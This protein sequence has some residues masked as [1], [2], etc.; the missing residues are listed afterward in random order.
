MNYKKILFIVGLIFIS[1]QAM[2]FKFEGFELGSSQNDVKEL[3]DPE[4]IYYL[5]PLAEED[6]T[7]K[8]RSSGKWI[9][10]QRSH[11]TIWEKSGNWLYPDALATTLVFKDHKLKETAIYW[12]FTKEKEAETHYSIMH[13]R[14]EDEYGAFFQGTADLKEMPK[15]WHSKEVAKDAR[16]H[17]ISRQIS[18]NLFQVKV[19]AILSK[20]AIIK[21]TGGNRY[22]EIN[23]GFSY[24]P[25][26]GWI[27]QKADF[28]PYQVVYG[29]RVAGFWTNIS[30]VTEISSMSLEEYTQDYSQKMS[31]MFT[32]F[33]IEKEEIFKTKQGLSGKKIVS[34][35]KNGD[36]QMRLVQYIFLD[37][38]IKLNVT[39]S[40]HPNVKAKFDR[41]FDDM[42][43]SLEFEQ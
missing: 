20:Q 15:K 14:L 21:R 10:I 40:A 13:R 4:N 36:V 19:S 23:G 9:V 22:F 8:A 35:A 39:C 26:K 41:Y 42:I 3:V 7:K 24:I 11:A 30:F 2:A 43:K 5:K 17:I 12:H 1:Q 31:S 16:L 38:N 37:G 34:N 29:E 18:A 25:P 33:A 27:I 6:K 32:A 28:S